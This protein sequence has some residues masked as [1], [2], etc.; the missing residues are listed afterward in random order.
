MDLTF[1]GGASYYR[2]VLAIAAVMTGLQF[3]PFF[4]WFLALAAVAAMTARFFETDLMCGAFVSLGMWGAHV[5]VNLAIVM[6]LKGG[7]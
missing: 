2:C 4:G 3:V 7:G 6:I 5:A 1:P